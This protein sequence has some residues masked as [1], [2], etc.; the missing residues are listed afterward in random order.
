MFDEKIIK[1]YLNCFMK[2]NCFMTVSKFIVVETI[3]EDYNI[4][5]FY[6]QNQC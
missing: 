3:F 6:Q 1:K 4:P 5:S 2:K